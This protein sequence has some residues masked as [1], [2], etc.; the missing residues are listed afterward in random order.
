MNGQGEA[1]KIDATLVLRRSYAAPPERVFRA[2]TDSGEMRRWYAADV[3]HE[4]HAIEVDLRVGGSYRAVFGKRG[5]DPYEERG[6]YTEIVPGR[7]LAFEMTL[8]QRGEVFS[9]SACA[10]DFID[11]GN[12]HTEV[13]LTDH[14]DDAGA[15]AQGWMP[16]LE[17]LGR[18][19]GEADRL[20]S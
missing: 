1:R 6:V 11:L 4:I 3:E 15:H 10:I 13:V 5:E 17:L 9:R 2:W 20:T 7:R 8:S 16:A 12:G 19:L 18:H 14:G